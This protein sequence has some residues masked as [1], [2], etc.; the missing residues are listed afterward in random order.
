MQVLSEAQSAL[1]E[2]VR[3]TIATVSPPHRFQQLDTAK[4]FDHELHA[5][6]GSIGVLGLGVPAQSGGSGGSCVDQMVALRALGNGATSMG[7]V[8]VVHFLCTR[9]LHANASP[10]QRGHCLR[11]L[12]TGASK[13]AFCLT[14]AEGGTDIL[15]VMQTAARRE[16]DDFVISGTKTWICGGELADFFIVVA[17]TSPG[18]TD[19]VSMFIVPR[20]TPGI[21]VR[22][23]DTFA[24]NAYDVCEVAFNDVRVP[25]TALLGTEGA[26]FRQLLAMLNAERLSVSANALGM[27]QGAMAL[28]AEYARQRKAFGKTLSEMQAVQLK[29]ANAAVAYELAWSYVVGAAQACDRGEAVDVDSAICKLAAVN[30]AE[31]AAQV[32][33]EIMGAAAF[34]VASPMQ[35]YYRDHRLYVIAP[36][37]NDMSRSLI[38]ERYFGFRRGF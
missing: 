17:R 29:L 28:A 18:K 14:E 13:A 32:G 10:D 25:A 23:I 24:V 20:Q 19:G 9:I 36:L 38:A 31:L 35:R 27:A 12:A 3:D 26:G 11:P 8:C 6:L 30:A 4:R 1:G 22:R 15:R 21:T 5:A 37:N 7:M 34:D 2:R 33:M 16:G